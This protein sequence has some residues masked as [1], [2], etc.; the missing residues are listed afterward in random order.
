VIA[1]S[2]AYAEWILLTAVVGVTN[3]M[4]VARH[5]A[6]PVVPRNVPRR[7]RT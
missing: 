3:I 6:V 1:P 4:T 2:A 5:D 7:S